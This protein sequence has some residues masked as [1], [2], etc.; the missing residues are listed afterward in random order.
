MRY[1]I[2]N[3]DNSLVMAMSYDIN[4][5]YKDLVAVCSAIRYWRAD[6]ALSTLD[7]LI[8]ME[9]P[10]PY[11][12]YNTHMGSRHELGGRKG[13]YPIKAAKMVRSTLINAMANARNHGIEGDGLFVVHAAANKTRIER[14][15][16]SKGS[17]A[18][19]RGMYGRS[20]MNHSDLEYAKIE[21]ALSEEDNK[22]LTEKM[23]YFI[24]KNSKGLKPINVVS[25]RAV[26]VIKKVDNKQSAKAA[27]AAAKQQE[28]AKPKT[29]AEVSPPKQLEKR[30]E[31]EQK[32]ENKASEKTT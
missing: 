8:E 7:R 2:D 23:K 11:H 13:A 32:K 15:Y 31:P 10:I 20:A 18:W 3:K 12:K 22:R 25:S 28:A 5:S 27:P 9:R 1:S 4:A 26:K 21:I 14:R 30:K 19:G 6:T 24:K 29:P 17:I 16:P